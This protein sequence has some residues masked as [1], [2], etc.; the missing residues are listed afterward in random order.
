MQKGISL[1]VP[2]IFV[3]LILISGTLLWKNIIKKSDLSPINLTTTS[4][5]PTQTSTLIPSPTLTAFST[6]E[7]INK[8]F[9]VTDITSNKE[10]YIGK[11]IKVSGKIE[12]R[13]RLGAGPQCVDCPSN[14]GQPTLHIVNP[15]GNQWVEGNAIDLYRK[16]GDGKYEPLT[17]KVVTTNSYDCGKY[18]NDS[19]TIVEGI[20]IKYQIPAQTVGDSTGRTEV[21]KWQDIYILVL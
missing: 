13:E 10:L 6:P 17:C 8:N 5:S 19:I 1:I 18:K 4:P 11:T 12:M 14:V 21:I 7:P 3:A 16:I 15:D 9:N 2:V 20:F